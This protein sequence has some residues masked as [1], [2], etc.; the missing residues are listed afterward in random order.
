[1]SINNSI[2]KIL[3]L[4]EENV[5]FN[6]NFVEERKIKKRLIKRM[7]EI[8]GFIFR[9]EGV[10]KLWNNDFGDTLILYTKTL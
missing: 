8:R 7:L 10:Q 9:V 3:N 4:K 5:N 6:E 2:L 1:M